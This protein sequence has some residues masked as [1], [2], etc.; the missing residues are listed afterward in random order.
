MK[1]KKLICLAIPFMLLG[2]CGVEKDY[3]KSNKGKEIMKEL[4]IKAL[5]M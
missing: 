2:G 5:V 1:A 3:S 4:K